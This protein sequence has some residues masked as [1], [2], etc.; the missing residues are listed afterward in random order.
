MGCGIFTNFTN[1]FSQAVISGLASNGIKSSGAIRLSLSSGS[2]LV[3]GTTGS[4]GFDSIY[5]VRQNHNGLPVEP[6]ASYKIGKGAVEIQ[7]AVLLQNG[8][9]LGVGTSY[10]NDEMLIVKFDTNGI[11]DKTFGKNGVVKTNIKDESQEEISLMGSSIAV[12]QSGKIFTTGWSQEIRA[13][14]ITCH[15]ANGELDNSFGKNGV[16]LISSNC[17]TVGFMGLAIKILKDDKIALLGK[18]IYS[19]ILSESYKTENF[20]AMLKPNGELITDFGKNGI[21]ILTTDNTSINSSPKE[22]LYNYLLGIS[23]INANK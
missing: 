11:F 2:K 18:A 3:A 13:M 9:V 5:I 14:I 23:T 19:E 1:V 16:V 7:E 20:V 6:V 22:I 4:K 21:E 15:L 8:F 12:A 10:Q 17:D